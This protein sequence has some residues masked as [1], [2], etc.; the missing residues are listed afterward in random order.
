MIPEGFFELMVMLFGLTNSPAMFQAMIN[1]LLRDLINT[2][3]VV[4]FINNMIVRTEDEE[5]YNGLVVEIVKRLE[6]NDLY[7]KLEKYKW[8]VKEIDFLGIV[9]GPEG[10]KIEEAKVKA[11]LDWLVLK[12]VKDIQ[13]FLGLANY[14]RRFIERFAKIARLLHELTRKDQKWD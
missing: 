2:E 5:G 12:S 11:V 1:E 4:A 13:K 6:E 9:L 8:K 10:I 3:K 7:I 14:Y